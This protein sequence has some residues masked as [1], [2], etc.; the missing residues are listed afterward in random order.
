MLLSGFLFNLRPGLFNNQ[1][2]AM[3]INVISLINK[4][5]DANPL[6]TILFL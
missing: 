2:N 4:E 3:V 1:H 5:D 6:P